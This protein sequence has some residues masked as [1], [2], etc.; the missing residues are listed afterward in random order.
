MDGLSKRWVGW[1]CLLLL[2]GVESLLFPRQS[3]GAEEAER[4][5][6]G[7]KERGYYDLAIEYL[8]DM[9]TN[10]LC[11]SNFR[12]VLDYELATTYIEW[13]TSGGPR[14]EEVL[15]QARSAFERFLREYPA[16]PEVGQAAFQLANV[17]VE[18]GKLKRQQAE[19]PGLAPPQRDRLLEEARHHLKQAEERFAAAERRA[20]ERART[21]EE[22][23]K[24]DPR[25]EADRDEARRQLLLARIHL[26]GVVYELGRTYP[27]N[28]A[29]YKQRL[30]DALKRYEELFEKYKAFTAGAYAGIQVGRIRRE[31]GDLPGSVSILKTVIALLSG[32]EGDDR[33]VA[34]EARAELMETYIAQKN[35]KEAVA[36]A[37]EWNKE[38]RQ[39]EQSTREGL[40]I[41]F[42]AGR[43][44]LEL[45]RQ[46]KPNSPE[47][48]QNVTSARRYLGQVARFPGS[49]RREAQALLND[50][51]FGQPALSD[52]QLPATYEEAREKGDEA[53]AR[54]V[55][56][57]G[58]LQQASNPQERSKI[59]EEL[60]SA[61]QEALDLYELSLRLQPEELS[62]QELTLI[63]FRMCYLFWLKQDYYRAA[64]LGEFLARTNPQSPLARQ[65][66]E[67]AAKAYRVLYIQATVPKE[68]RTFETQ[69]LRELVAWMSETWPTESET[70]EARMMLLD[71]AV[72]N[73]Q[74]EEA[75]QVLSQIPENSPRR[76][77]GEIRLGQAI[78]SSYAQAVD[79][80]AEVPPDKTSL[81]ALVEEAQKWLA[82]GLERKKAQLAQGGSVDFIMV[83]AA[84]ELARVY[85]ELGRPQEAVQLL[86]D[87]SFGP[88]TLI[89]KN[90]PLVQ[91]G[92]FVTDTLTLALRVYVAVQDLERAEEIMAEL[93]RAVAAAGDRDAAQR[94]TQVYIS[95]ARQLQGSL[96]RL[97]QEGRDQEAETLT[98]GF[99]L[100][101]TKL[102]GRDAGNTFTTLNWVAET[103]YNLGLSLEGGSESEQTRARE[104]Y[105]SAA[106]V[107]LDILKKI[108]A[109]STGQFAPPG[110]ELSVQLRLAAALR[111]MGQYE[112]AINLL[113]KL[114]QANENRVNVQVELA[115]TYQAWGDATDKAEY[116]HM[117][118]TG[119]HKHE[120]R[121]VFWG[122]QGIAR[123]VAPFAQYKNIFHEAWYN[124]MLCRMKQ[125]LLLSERDPR[126]AELLRQAETDAF[127]IYQLY[128]DMGGEEM[129]AKYDALL[130]RVQKLR[131]IAN[132]S[133]IDAVVKPSTRAVSRAGT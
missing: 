124:I 80:A 26:A 43:A 132:P 27:S 131:G 15:E 32:A 75:R 67:I 16:R 4:F 126:R 58:R 65:A 113:V 94:L 34:N 77:E 1:L 60:L 35:F 122:W 61:T 21:L 23:A 30:Q 8:Q 88:L 78:W 49:L 24:K 93:E 11:P 33:L 5:V 133:G 28:S 57:L 50:P 12:E 59:E 85:L 79:L 46:A 2:L 20:Y 39:G 92:N 107:Y 86:E 29:D 19:Q 120:N 7:L 56:G 70:T 104:Y 96:R 81:E 45:A 22:E 108:R 119:G 53:W 25:R 47:Q 112:Q 42:A 123:R 103:F 98:K 95:L 111:G 121:N 125:A 64:V 84:R 62:A 130:R 128:P 91:R 41:A 31:L 14:T 55:V 68:E 71:T 110:A 76:A 54:L 118:I 99:E 17:L 105:K 116:Y 6:R 48:R 72:D 3:A 101:L 10:P 102:R 109:D 66:A 87:S 115:K 100:F 44:A 117:A 89:R 127:R 74:L 40:M 36:V 69:K 13:I 114:L 106:S 37:E 9:R 38:A 63:R 97:R 52:R 129:R 83:T 73:R 51:L 18:L 82:Q 90:D